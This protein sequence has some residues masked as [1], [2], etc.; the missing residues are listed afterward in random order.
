MRA[1]P[2]RDW[3]DRILGG[4]VLW[5]GLAALT[6]F[7]VAPFVWALPADAP[8]LPGRSAPAAPHRSA[9]TADRP[10]VLPMLLAPR[11]PRVRLRS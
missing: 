10:S 4:P 9:G 2:R 11:A 1:A 7:A 5:A 6:L 8:G 3:A